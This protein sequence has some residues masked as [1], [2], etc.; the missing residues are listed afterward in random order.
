MHQAPP[1]IND[2]LQDKP[3]KKIRAKDTRPAREVKRNIKE[4]TRKPQGRKPK[5]AGANNPNNPPSAKNY[6]WITPDKFPIIDA[7]AREPGVKFSGREI[8][9][10]LHSRYPQLFGAIHEQTVYGWIDSSTC[11]WNDR[12]LQCSKVWDVQYNR[13]GRGN[14]IFVSIN[15][16]SIS[17]NA[18]LCPEKPHRC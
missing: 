8:T 6:N 18:H 4:R 5:P 16:F 14:G 13:H 7:I 15:R 9:N 10:R 2:V 11:C 1:S 3:T 12:V 17:S